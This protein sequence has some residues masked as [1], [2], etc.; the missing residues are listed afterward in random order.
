METYDKIKKTLA[1][2]FMH[3]LDNNRPEGKMCLSNGECADI[4]KAF[5]EQDWPKLAR[6]LDKYT[7]SEDE[8]IRKQL[9][10]IMNFLGRDNAIFSEG[11]ITKEQAIA[12]LEKQ[13]PKPI[14]AVEVLARA[15]LKPYKDGNQ[16]CILAG[17]NIQE[18]IC[19][20]GDT[21]EDALY[22]FLKEILDLQKEQK[23][24]SSC[25]IVPYIDD[26]IAALQDMWR[27]E[28]VAF[29]WDDIHEMIEDVAR[30]FYQKEQIPYIDFVIKPHKGDD[31]NPYDMGVS[32]AQE[33]AIK[34]GFGIPFNDGEVFVDERY[35]TQTIGNILRWADEH[36]K[37]QTPHRF[38]DDTLKAIDKARE[39]DDHEQNP[40]WSEEDERILTGIIERGSSQVPFGE[41]ALR[42]EQ[43]EWLMN[44]L[45][46]LRPQPKQEWSEEDE[47]KR[48]GLIKGLEDRMG[49]G[50]ASDPFSREE[51]IA[52][53]KSLRPSW[54]PSEEQMNELW[55]AISYIELPGSNY[56]GV[57]ELLE[58]IYEQLKKLM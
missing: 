52:W 48:N 1:V 18:G 34:R 33:Y 39:F 57:P 5:D 46:S 37:E 36:P 38:C 4:E 9:I 55:S 15:G 13:E 28:K 17:D 25:D 42:G 23:P 21:I 41:P 11:Q 53:L 35:I 45:K 12:Y 44:R 16:W 50:W 6:Y 26:E 56:L 24:I 40:A 58:S 30:H 47:K 54:K 27:E 51:Y 32:E 10:S 2:A 20:F 49:F 3:D 19:G 31:G 22:E 29:D 14:S 43:M 8:R 7:E